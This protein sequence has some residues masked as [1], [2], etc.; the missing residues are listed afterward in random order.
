MK[1]NSAEM[2][3]SNE[4]EEDEKEIITLSSV[5]RQWAIAKHLPCYYGVRIGS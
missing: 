5:E 3:E 2:E 1:W 4:V